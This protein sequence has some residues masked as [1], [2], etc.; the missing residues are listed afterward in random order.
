MKFKILILCV[1][2]LL[3]TGS[4]LAQDYS[5]QKSQET[6][7]VN[8]E[9]FYVHQVVKGNTLYN[10]SKAYNVPTNAITHLNPDLSEGLKLGMQLKIPFQLDMQTDYIY[11]IVKKKETLY[12][13][14]KI[15]NVTVDDLKNLNQIQD[16]EISPGQYLKIPSMFVQSNEL[17]LHQE[18]TEVITVQVDDDKNITYTVQPKETLYTI[19]KRFGMSIDALMYIND[20]NSSNLSTGQ[21]LLI[22]RKL[23]EIAENSSI[24]TTQFIQHKV[25][26]KETLYGIARLYAV[27]II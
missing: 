11:H 20:L 18:A 2:G 16:E 15:Y 3:L 9:K 10:I 8:G 1:F 26:P 6:M 13:I 5:A 17:Q 19:S 27:P 14:S 7:V 25:K 23:V 24:D 21:V 12:Q 4:T 22:P